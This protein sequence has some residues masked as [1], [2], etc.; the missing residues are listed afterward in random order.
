[1]VEGEPLQQ[2]HIVGQGDGVVDPHNQ[3]TAVGET[4]DVNVEGEQLSVEQP[5]SEY[6]SKTPAADGGTPWL[7]G[8]EHVHVM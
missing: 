4:Q 5:H 3:L 7:I 8:G 6:N 2:L 1:M